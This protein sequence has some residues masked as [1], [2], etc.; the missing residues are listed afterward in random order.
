MAAI[1][2][3]GIAGVHCNAILSLSL[4]I[5]SC[6]KD[7]SLYSA[8]NLAACKKKSV[9]SFFIQFVCHHISLNT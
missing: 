3:P 7:G 6:L 2:R 5:S 1:Q 9:G 8:A 4:G